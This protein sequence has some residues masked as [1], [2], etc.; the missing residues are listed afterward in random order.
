MRISNF[1][2][3]DLITTLSEMFVTGSDTISTT[4]KWMFLY[5][6]KFQNV[7]KKI[8]QEIDSVIPKN[9]LPTLEDKTK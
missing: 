3:A 9:R 4:L 5:M 1:L 2:D 6:A 8:H 7:Q